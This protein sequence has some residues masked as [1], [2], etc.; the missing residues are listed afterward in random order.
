M[1]KATDSQDEVNE[2]N[3]SNN[4]DVEDD[5]ASVGTLLQDPASN[6]RS[7]ITQHNVLLSNSGSNFISDML[8]TT[9]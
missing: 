2:I 5:P 6:P 4:S 8:W 1:R 7:D 3:N 9:W